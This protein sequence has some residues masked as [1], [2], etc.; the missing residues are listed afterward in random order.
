ME[1]MHRIAKKFWL[2]AVI[3]L[4]AG[5]LLA[6]I[7]SVS[8]FPQ[9]S[10]ISSD[11]ATMAMAGVVI[12]AGAL[13]MLIFAQ[14]DPLL[15]IGTCVLG[16]ISLILISSSH[17]LVTWWTEDVLDGYYCAVCGGSLVFIAADLAVPF[18]IL[19]RIKG[20]K[21]KEPT[22]VA[23][24]RTAREEATRQRVI[25]KQAAALRDLQVLFDNGLISQEEFEGEKRRLSEALKTQMPSSDE[26]VVKQYRYQNST[27]RIKGSTFVLLNGTN[28]IKSGKVEFREE[29]EG[30]KVI[31]VDAEGKRYA[32]FQK[33]DALETK[34]GIRYEL[35]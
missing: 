26:N 30:L 28:V 21:K 8:M 9:N 17:E 31:L 16:T 19:S 3:V 15:A 1:K 25:A 23:Q 13:I 2:A 35:L 11:G 24:R 32:F 27:I 4:S 18:M 12:A 6:F 5:I 10:R 7:G 20:V 14:K 22:I 29:E 33:E 34:S